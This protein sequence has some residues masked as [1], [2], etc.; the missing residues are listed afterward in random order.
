MMAH[1]EVEGERRHGRHLAGGPS[2][3]TDKVRDN[4]GGD[5]GG[6]EELI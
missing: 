5:P 1:G 2:G 6:V 4:G 3:L